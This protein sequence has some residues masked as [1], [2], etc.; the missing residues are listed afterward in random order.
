MGDAGYDAR[1][2]GQVFDAT[3]AIAKRSTVASEAIRVLHIGFQVNEAYGER[4]N[5]DNV[6][7]MV[8]HGELITMFLRR[9]NQPSTTTALRV[10]KITI[11]GRG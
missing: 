6:W 7:A 11:I 2:I 10:E 4:S 8:R 5:G 1:T 9:S 3:L